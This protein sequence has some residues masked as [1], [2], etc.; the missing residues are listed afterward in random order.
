[1]QLGKTKGLSKRNLQKKVKIADD[2]SSVGTKGRK[3]ALKDDSV[4]GS[5]NTRSNF[6]FKKMATQRETSVLST[7]KVKKFKNKAGGKTMIN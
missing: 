3:A 6:G 7:T 4:I 5:G 1:M 2:A